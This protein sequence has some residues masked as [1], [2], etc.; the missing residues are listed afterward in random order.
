MKPT[1]WRRCWRI[2][3]F[4]M[5]PENIRSRVM[6]AERSFHAKRIAPLLP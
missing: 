6:R 4:D 3:S 1:E 5:R 2:A